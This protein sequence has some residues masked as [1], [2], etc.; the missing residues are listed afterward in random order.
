MSDNTHVGQIYLPGM[1]GQP[2]GKFQFLVETSPGEQGDGGRDLEVGGFVS[3]DTDEG[4]VVGTV[5]DMHAI[6][7][8]NDP[9]A[10]DL[11]SATDTALMTK[12]P[13]VTL[14]S[15]QV[16]HSDKL[17]PV[18]AGKVR[19]AT[20]SEVSTALGQDKMKWRIPVGT[21]K[22]GT[23]ELLDVGV[24]GESVLGVEAQGLCVGGRAGAAKTSFLTVALRS[25]MTHASKQGLSTAM[26]AINVK[27]E[28]LLW[29]SEPPTK[30]FALEDTDR[31]M[32]E[33]L[34][35]EAS[36]FEK[37][38]VY[39]P[40]LPGGAE[41]NCPRDDAQLLR[42]DL[43]QVWPYL[44]Q[45]F[46]EAMENANL[47]G[48]LADIKEDLLNAQSPVKRKRTL[49]QLDEW[50]KDRFAELEEDETGNGKSMFWKSH[51][52]ATGRRAH[53]MLLSLVTR[54]GG[55]L[56]KES[57]KPEYDVPVTGLEDGE[58]FVLDI[59]NLAPDVQALV[60]GRTVKRLFAAAERGETGVDRVMLLSDEL[61][62]WAPRGPAG[63]YAGVRRSLRSV[64]SRGRYAG[65]SLWAAA[66]QLSKV[67]ETILTN[68]SSQALGITNATEL[69]T[70]VYGKLS[71]G[72]YEQ[73]QVQRKGEMTL[74][75]TEFR[76]P[77]K[78][79]FPR[80]CFQTGKP[81][82]DPARK[83][84]RK[85]ATDVLPVS[86]ASKEKLMEGIPQDVA[87]QVVAQE[88][89]PMR[90]L[91]KLKDLRVPDIRKQHL[92]QPKSV[93]ED[94]PFGLGD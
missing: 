56:S 89:D 46:P 62:Q 12:L 36:P 1:P 7:S 70:G 61:N 88:D 78:I 65:V 24:D 30:S 44:N 84:R 18:R 73:I 25:A 10:A 11:S 45:I 53:R 81:D 13:E 38:T 9:I 52:V 77:I 54:F 17:R 31:A 32:Y 33:A 57:T 71:S 90:A 42:W 16:L 68:A 23:G 64:A 59:A 20:R 6:G 51:H 47:A 72:V 94:D 37:V 86:D 41:P 80:P 93:D 14:A 63:E 39:A 8:V 26:I 83:K 40:S 92:H 91:E 58:V 74:W 85:V 67:D 43:M 75:H 50:F 82:A 22:L 66:Q 35:V 76:V 60:I 29:L 48:L 79:N 19:F 87:D 34:G 2:V 49:A 27:G 28:D 15:A 4:T 21:V 55:L 69:G 3:V 5:T